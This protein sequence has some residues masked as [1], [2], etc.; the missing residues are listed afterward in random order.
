MLLVSGPSR[1]TAISPSG[2]AAAIEGWPAEDEA[3]EM[4]ELVVSHV[5]VSQ[6]LFDVRIFADN[7]SLVYT[8]TTS[9]INI[10]ELLIV[11]MCL[12][13]A[14]GRLLQAKSEDNGDLPGT[15]F[16]N[17]AMRRMPTCL[18]LRQHH[19]L[20]IE[21]P[22]LTALYLQITDRKIDAYLYVRFL[23]QALL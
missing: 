19:L 7:M 20:G 9:Q 12:V 5:G 13:F 14:I 18:S 15:K 22:A 8:E 16:F 6:Q 3:N 21:V 23:G 4:L 17:E 11:Q 2:S 10:A 1:A